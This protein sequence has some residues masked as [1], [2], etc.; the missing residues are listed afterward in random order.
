MD[1]RITMS[2]EPDWVVKADGD[3]DPGGHAEAVWKSVTKGEAVEAYMYAQGATSA[4][5]RQVVVNPAH[6]RTV[7][8]VPDRQ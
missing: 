4:E 6:V 7:H 8:E 1:V 2:S 5:S 3:A